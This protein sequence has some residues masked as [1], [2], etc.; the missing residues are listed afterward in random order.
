MDKI[1]KIRNMKIV[2]LK[3][4]LKANG[5]KG[6]STITKKSLEKFIGDNEPDLINIDFNVPLPAKAMKPC[7]EGEERNKN[8]G[9]CR[10]KKVYKDCG[11]G[12]ERNENTK[13]CRDT[14][15]TK[16]GKRTVKKQRKNEPKVEKKKEPKKD[17]PSDGLEP[18]PVNSK[19]EYAKQALVF[20]PD[21]NTGCSGESTKKMAT[22]NVLLQEYQDSLMT[23]KELEKM[24]YKEAKQEYMDE[25]K[26]Q[27]QEFDAHRK[28]ERAQEK[29]KAKKAKAEEMKKQKEHEKEMKAEKKKIEEIKQKIAKEKERMDR[30]QEEFDESVKLLKKQRE[31][32][33]RR[34]EEERMKVRN[35]AL[36]EDQFVNDFDTVAAAVVLFQHNPTAYANLEKLI[37]KEI[38]RNGAIDIDLL[39]SKGVQIPLQTVKKLVLRYGIIHTY[40]YTYDLLKLMNGDVTAVYADEIKDNYNKS[41]TLKA[42]SLTKKEMNEVKKEDEDAVRNEEMGANDINV[43]PPKKTEEKI[44]KDIKKI[45]KDNEKDSYDD[46]LSFLDPES[47]AKAEKTLQGIKIPK[48]IFKKFSKEEVDMWSTMMD[49]LEK[50][51]KKKKK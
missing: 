3:A 37:D 33:N 13:R 38:K 49:N 18:K 12:R 51:T 46:P 5:I 6:F 2:D 50:N 42:L 24:R 30:E 22:L 25:N 8:T 32:Q 29:E 28:K 45:Y 27:R 34:E 43:M 31:E 23:P 9:R 26:K 20:H 11:E 36:T 14:A 17:C 16:R 39:L 40:K 10:K 41:R 7:K 44:K 15:E 1:F 35:S 19:I 21:K 4:V 48:D 47:R